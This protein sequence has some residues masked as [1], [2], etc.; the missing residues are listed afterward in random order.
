MYRSFAWITAVLATVL[1]AGCG[2]PT[3]IPSDAESGSALPNNSSISS[4]LP[5]GVYSGTVDC[6]TTTID[7]F[8]RVSTQPIPLAV[9]Y[10]ISDRGIPIVQGQ[11]IRVGRTVTIGGLSVT[12][13]RIQPTRNGIVVHSDT[14][15]RLGDTSGSGIATCEFRTTGTAALEY[16][17]TQGF[18]DDTGAMFNES[19]DGLLSP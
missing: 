7:A 1:S 9:T 18:A 11:E 19:C 10:E 5:E 6:D 8:G 4:S 12:Y 3:S 2:G 15:S 17:C 14:A 16:R 13:T